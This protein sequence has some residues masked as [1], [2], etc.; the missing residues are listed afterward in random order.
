MWR[1]AELAAL[2][3]RVTARIS[4]ARTTIHR[5]DNTALCTQAKPGPFPVRG[6]ACPAIK[7]KSRR[8]SNRD[9]LRG[10]ARGGYRLPMLA[11][12][13]E[14]KFNRFADQVSCLVQCLGGDAQTRQI[15]NVVALTCCG[16]LVDNQILH[17]RPACLRTLFN[18]GCPTAEGL[19]FPRRL[20]RRRTIRPTWSAN[21]SSKPSS[22]DRP[23]PFAVRHS[24]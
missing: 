18:V 10:R 15:G 12:T 4:G 22:V 7:G 14:K 24:A 5:D 1:L 2:S 16:L 19:H 11:H 21:V 8:P 17:F 13:F 6:S 3:H 23:S 20:H 9:V